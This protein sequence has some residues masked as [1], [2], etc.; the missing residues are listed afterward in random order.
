MASKIYRVVDPSHVYPIYAVEVL[1]EDTTEAK[2]L[3]LAAILDCP[4]DD[5]D[6]TVVK[7]ALGNLT[8]EEMS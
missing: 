5:V 7:E 6:S 2:E 4:L 1:A 8:V 3:A